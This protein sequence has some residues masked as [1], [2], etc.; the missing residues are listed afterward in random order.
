MMDPMRKAWRLALWMHCILTLCIV[1][2]VTFLMYELLAGMGVCILH[3]WKTFFLCLYFINLEFLVCMQWS[4]PPWVVKTDR[5]TCTPS[6][7]LDVL[8]LLRASKPRRKDTC[9]GMDPFYPASGC[10]CQWSRSVFATYL[11]IL[12]IKISIYLR[13]Y[14]RTYNVETGD[15]RVFYLRI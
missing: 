9:W 13:G 2:T 12:D 1:A 4:G 8:W 10:D 15:W 3:K 14:Y 7:L 6:K 5:S 11:V